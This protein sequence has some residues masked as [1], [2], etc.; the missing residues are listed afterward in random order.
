MLRSFHSKP[1][2]FGC[3][4]TCNTFVVQLLTRSIT[5]VFVA[6]FDNGKILIGS[7]ATTPVNQLQEWSLSGVHVSQH[8]GTSSNMLSSRG[9]LS[10]LFAFS[11][12]L[13]MSTSWW[14]AVSLLNRY[15]IR[16]WSLLDML[17]SYQ[18]W[19]IGIPA[20]EGSSFLEKHHSRLWYF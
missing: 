10:C 6:A 18:N 13:A 15:L 7:G 20:S 12:E 1:W 5:V 16:C 14:V 2:W 9:V 8:G 11:E 3:N 19:T 4:A 17:T